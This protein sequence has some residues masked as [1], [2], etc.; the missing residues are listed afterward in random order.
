MRCLISISS[1]LELMLLTLANESVSDFDNTEETS[2]D[3][4]SKK[5]LSRL[6]V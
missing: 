2:V 3:D 1:F 5:I 6:I 4:V